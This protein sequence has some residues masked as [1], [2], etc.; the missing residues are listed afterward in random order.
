MSTQASIDAVDKRLEQQVNHP[1]DDDDPRMFQLPIK[2]FANS[3]IS[4]GL[5]VPLA[6]VC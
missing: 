6:S 5:C 1:V 2:P 3:S 4:T